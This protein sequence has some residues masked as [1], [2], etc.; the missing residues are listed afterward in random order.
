M[1]GI[2]GVVVVWAICVV[3]GSAL[4]HEA[5]PCLDC[6]SCGLEGRRRALELVRSCS[7]RRPE[8]QAR[9][10]LE[11][12]AR[13][14]C[15]H[16][17]SCARL[18]GRHGPSRAPFGT[19]SPRVCVQHLGLAHQP[20]PGSLVRWRADPRGDKGIPSMGSRL[21]SSL[22][23]TARAP[24]PLDPQVVGESRDRCQRSPVV[25]HSRGRTCSPSPT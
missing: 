3:G 17:R 9:A 24:A 15:G 12:C 4:L 25:A 16:R 18:P 21:K 13:R 7:R 8:W 5:R 23:H 1:P 11:G 20:R 22:V 10:H 2:F 14:T 6:S 19:L